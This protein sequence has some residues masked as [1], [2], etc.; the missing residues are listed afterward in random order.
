MPKVSDSDTASGHANHS[1]LVYDLLIKC[2]KLGAR[3]FRNQVGQY[4]LARPECVT[5]QRE[6]RILRS[7]LCVGS[8]DLIGWAPVVI[9]AEHVGRTVAVFTAIDAKTGVGRATPEQNT[10]AR[11]V[12]GHGGL[13]CVARSVEDAEVLFAPWMEHKP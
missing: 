12:Q 6:G 5:C 7:G 13:V 4:R 9:T 3:M 11:V 8:L 2:S 1:R 10:F